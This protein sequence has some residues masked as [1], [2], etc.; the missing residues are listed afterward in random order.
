MKPTDTNRPEKKI[1]II[2]GPNGSGKTTFAEEFLPNEAGCL[3]FVNADLIAAGLAPFEPERAAFRAGRLMLEE[4]CRHSRKG[5]SFSF[6]TTLSGR[7]YA[8][9]IPVWRAEGYIVKLFFL[10]LASPDL[11]IARVRQ[12]VR[13]GGHNIPEPV[14]RRRFD[15]GL[16]NFENLYKPLVDEW[17]L[18]DNSGSEPVLIEEGV[19][20]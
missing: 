1:I 17:A 2:A 13:E 5:E 9:L 15:S 12:R 4:I 7:G 3:T 10:G 18:Y 19:N 14:I 6:E 8:G 16:R 20:I 11:A